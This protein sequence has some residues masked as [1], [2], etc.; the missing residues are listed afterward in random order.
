MAIYF[1]NFHFGIIS[2]LQKV[3]KMAQS[4]HIPFAQTP[5]MLT[6]PRF[7]LLSFFL[8]AHASTHIFFP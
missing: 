1:L 4:S 6:L 8:R 2:N 3:V 5:Q 7:I